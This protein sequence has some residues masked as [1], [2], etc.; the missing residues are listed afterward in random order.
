MLDL[1]TAFTPELS[2]EDVLERIIKVT[3]EV[4][5]VQRASVFIVDDEAEELILK[6]SRDVKGVRVPMKGMC[7]HVAKTGDLLNIS[8]AY[9]DNRFD[10]AMDKKSSF[11]TKQVLCVPVKAGNDNAIVGVMQCINT[12]DDLPFTQQDEDLLTMVSKQLGQVLAK[13]SVATAFT[14]DSKF[15]PVQDVSNQFRINIKSATTSKAFSAVGKEHRHISCTAQLYH[16]G[17]KLGKEMMVNNTQTTK[18][19]RTST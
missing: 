19:V 13:Q 4:F 6:V 5:C 8:D 15:I 16:G 2:L 7:G 10:P 18:K 1:L 12:V 17:V 3:R 11:R 9:D 14:D